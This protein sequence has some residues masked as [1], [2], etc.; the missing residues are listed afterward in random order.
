MAR[1]VLDALLD[2]Y[3][4]EGVATIEADNILSVQPFTAL[5]SPAELVKSFGGRPQYRSA[6]QALGHALYQNA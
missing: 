3:A 4:D 6:L 2:K 5:G 1:K